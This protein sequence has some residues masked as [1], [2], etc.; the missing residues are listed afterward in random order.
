MVHNTKKAALLFSR[1][2]AFIDKLQ[3]LRLN[4]LTHSK[5]I[6]MDVHSTPS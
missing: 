2:T 5:A 4:Q 1:K 6:K 3:G